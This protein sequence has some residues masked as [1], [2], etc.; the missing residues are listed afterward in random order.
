MQVLALVGFAPLFAGVARCALV[1]IVLA[2]V[3]DARD[4]GECRVGVLR[5]GG[6]AWVGGG[7]CC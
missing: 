1:T 4:A 7:G 5:A 2:L 6:G 3:V